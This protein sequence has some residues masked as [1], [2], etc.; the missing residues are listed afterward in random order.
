MPSLEQLQE[1]LAQAEQKRDAAVG[2]ITDE[3]KQEIALRQKLAQLEDER[4]AAVLD[5]RRLDLD[6]REDTAKDE[7]GPDAKIDSVLLSEDSFVLLFQPKAYRAWKKVQVRAAN[8]PKVDTDKAEIDFAVACIIDWNGQTDFSLATGSD[9]THRLSEHLKKIEVGAII[10]A[11][12]GVGEVVA[13][14]RKS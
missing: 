13:E 11:L 1:R 8:D 2:S 3:E 10:N 7:H 12:I 6:R 4:R 5:K 14:A 9:N